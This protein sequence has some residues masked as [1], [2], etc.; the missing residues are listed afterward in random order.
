MSASPTAS[1]VTDAGSSHARYLKSLPRRTYPL[2]VLGLG[3]GA[4]AVFAVLR[5]LD[6]PAW[7]WA[8]TT[9]CCFAWPHVAFVWASRSRDPFKAELRNFVIDSAL[10]GSL[11]PL[12]H[13]NLLPSAVLMAVLFADKLNTGVRKLWLRALPGTV[14]AIFAM[15][16]VTGFEVRLESS[17]AVIAS[18]L[19]ILVIHTI[20]VALSSYKLLRKVQKQNVLLEALSRTDALTGVHN[21]GHWEPS[22]RALLE[23]ATPDRPASL[24]VLDIDAFKDINDLHGHLHGDDVLKAIGALLQRHAGANGIAGRLGGDEFALAMPIGAVE[25][26]ALAERLRAEAQA[27]CF[28]T[29]PE[30]RC[31]ISLG[32]ASSSGQFVDFRAWMEAADRALYRAKQSGRNRTA[33]QGMASA[34]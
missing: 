27:L 3:M 16:V 29:A 32:V 11:V 13:F 24:L 34:N 23:A 20:G 22:A 30:L 17:L 7:A 25:A 2:R 10:A 28:E 26:D 14:A 4:L 8:W 6:A 19:P 12:M 21:R 18:S 5:E 15:G 1:R 9:F 33:S 31:S